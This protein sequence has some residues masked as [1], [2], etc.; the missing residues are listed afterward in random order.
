MIRKA[1]IQD[2]DQLTTLFDQYL[3]FYKKPSN[4]EKHKSYLKDRIENNEAIIFM[5][6]DDELTEKAIGF[7]L[8]YPTFSSILLNKILI[9]NDLYVDTSIRNK[10]TGE[11]LILKTVALAQELDIKIVR[12]R[13]AKNNVI[14]QGLYHKMGF[15]KDELVYTYDLAVK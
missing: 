5:A 11:K 13:T 14:A 8:I 2:L 9:L 7:T 4:I 12:L 1:T 3:V 15:V 6:F 10:G